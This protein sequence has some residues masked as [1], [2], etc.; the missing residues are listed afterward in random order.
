MINESGV[1]QSGCR[2]PVRCQARSSQVSQSVKLA[3]LERVKTSP[4]ILDDFIFSISLMFCSLLRYR[5]SATT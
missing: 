1:L 5:I 2:D 4:E 3:L